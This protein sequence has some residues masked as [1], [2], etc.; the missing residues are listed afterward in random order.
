[1]RSP[2]ILIYL[3]EVIL[4]SGLFTSCND[5]LDV[6]PDD[7][8]TIEDAFNLRT[9]AEQYF[10]TCYSYLPNF[11]DP[12]SNPGIAGGDE[13]W[14]YKSIFDKYGWNP[15]RLG[16]G[17]QN[18]LDPYCNWWDGARGGKS[19]FQ[20]VRDCNIFI[21]NIDRT[22]GIDDE[23]KAKWK[24]EVNVLKAFYH[25]W[26]MQLYGP[27]PIMDENMSI[28]AGVEEV[29]VYRRPI[30]EVVDYIVSTI[31]NACEDLPEQI[32]SPTDEQGRIDQ[33]VAKAIKANVL[34]TAASPLFNGNEDLSDMVD[35]QGT[36]LFPAY[37]AELWNQAEIACK[38]AI[39]LCHANNKT[40]YYFNDF[41]SAT[42]SDTT[43]QKMNIRNSF[44]A[45]ENYEAIWKYSKSGTGTMQRR[46]SPRFV[47]V[48][49]T[50]E[51]TRVLAPT[52]RMAELFYT[53]NGVPIE[54][55]KN[56]SGVDVLEKVKTTDADRYNIQPDVTTLRLNLQR[57]TRFYASLA[58]DRSYWFGTGGMNDESLLPVRAK[59]G[60]PGGLQKEKDYSVTG[61]F[62]KKLVNYR[63]AFSSGTSY[64]VI[65]YQ[66][67]V[68]R[69]TD[70]YLLYA[71]AI[72][73]NRGPEDAYYY[74]DEVRK[75]ASLKG[76][77]ESYRDYSNNPEKP[78]T[79]E[80]F[81]DIIRRERLIELA[82]EGKRYFDLRR[83]KLSKEYLNKPIRGY[84][85]M[86]T[87]GEN[88]DDFYDIVVID[89]PLF[90]DKD[91]FYPIKEQDLYVNKNL[92]Q[93]K[94][95]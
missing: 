38:E 65:N 78:T 50:D 48:S 35:N 49:G 92:V 21:E 79:K 39:D 9:S 13:Y 44:A 10:F 32:E 73:E 36:I 55:D 60:Q 83:W 82:F 2:K 71:E 5:Y 70:L 3:M 77:V 62:P 1:M 6:V 41:I 72:N 24:A 12:G 52:F 20:A 66:M 46:S 75:R 22:L 93:N 29:K 37:N 54:E 64:T 88:E 84:N 67:P 8:A 47:T 14:F 19:M 58:F 23:E 74:I 11:A 26:L 51:P 17:E 90:E 34:V 40:L 57:E 94:G 45:E 16:R 53:E 85:I 86:V 33:M 4:L 59:R 42:L 56:W 76:V 30:N 69:L 89:E 28:D 18:I 27:I 63:N 7:T 68:I 95:W 91:Y 61:M 87:A 15:I 80:G 81:R 43:I 25:F 31:D